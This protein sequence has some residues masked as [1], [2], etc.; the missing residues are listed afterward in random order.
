M[1]AIV[2]RLIKQNNYKDLATN[3]YNKN[4]FIVNKNNFANNLIASIGDKTVC[5]V[6]FCDIDGLKLTNDIFGHLEADKGIKFIA[7]AIKIN[8]KTLNCNSITIRFG[9]D[10]FITLLHGCTKKKALIIAKKIKQDIIINTNKAKGMTLAIGV[11]SSDELSFNNKEYSQRESNQVFNKLL[12]LAEKNMF[13]DKNKQIK[14]LTYIEKKNIVLK[15]INRIGEK[16]GFN[17]K[18][19]KQIDLLIGILE[20]L[21]EDI[22]KR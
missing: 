9:G 5:S 6:L 18:S 20:D 22:K 21:K 14:N 10:E 8:S 15:H 2:E 19:P 7:N 17:I 1:A 13:I 12:K 3:L 4:F 11:A 16:V